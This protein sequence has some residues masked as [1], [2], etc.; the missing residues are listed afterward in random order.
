MQHAMQLVQN[1]VL[2]DSLV[3]A[4]VCSTEEHPQAMAA[5]PAEQLSLQ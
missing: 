5:A 1:V 4:L 3:P 2:V